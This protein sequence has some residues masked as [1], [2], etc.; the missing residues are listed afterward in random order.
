VG[1]A[2]GLG[3]E[4]EVGVEDEDGAE[5]ATTVESLLVAVV[6]VTVPDGREDDEALDNEVLDSEALDSEALDDEVLIELVVEESL[7]DD[8]LV[9]DK[10]VEEETVRSRLALEVDIDDGISL[11]L[12]DNVLLVVDMLGVFEE[13]TDF[14]DEDD[15]EDRVGDT[16]LELQ[17]PNPP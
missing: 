4:D 11:K 5:D 14:E 13:V 15:A 9:V 10:V 7:T 1:V 12:E 3:V 6:R 8:E 16:G 17:S 2:D